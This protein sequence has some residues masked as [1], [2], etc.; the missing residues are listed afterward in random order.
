M[1]QVMDMEPVEVFRTNVGNLKAADE[2]VEAVVSLF[3]HLQVTFDLEDCDNVLR[4]AGRCSHA[5][6]QVVRSLV[7]LHGFE[8][9]VLN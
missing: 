3:P 1:K 5:D 9:H 4:I 7:V 6:M 8:M 2:I